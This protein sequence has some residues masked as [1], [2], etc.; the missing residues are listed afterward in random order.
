MPILNFH[1]LLIVIFLTIL[2]RTRKDGIIKAIHEIFMFLHKF[3]LKYYN[4]LVFITKIK[5][6]IFING[7]TMAQGVRWTVATII[8]D[9]KL[10][11]FW[12][13][14]EITIISLFLCCILFDR[15][16]LSLSFDVVFHEMVQ[17]M[18]FFENFPL[19]SNDFPLSFANFVK[20]N[21]YSSS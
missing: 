13:V 14:K 16:Y 12:S 2:H 9:F 8:Y 19:F 1:H 6:I 17:K 18:P 3:K 20:T 5:N 21:V 15:F 11:L 4:L 10:F 7:F